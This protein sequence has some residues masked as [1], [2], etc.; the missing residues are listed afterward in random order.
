M[1]KKLMVIWGMVV[2]TL[3][4]TL[5]LIGVYKMDK[6]LWKLERDLKTSSKKYIK[7]KNIDIKFNNS[8][9]VTIEELIDNDYIKK[10]ESLDKYCIKS[11]IVSKNLFYEYKVNKDCNN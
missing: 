2:V 5:I 11:V 1:S 10:T 8:Y 9:V 7:N 4:L 3:F 6:V